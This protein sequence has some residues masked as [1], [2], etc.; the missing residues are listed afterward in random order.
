MPRK[1]AEQPRHGGRRP[2]S[3]APR[4]NLNAVKTGAQSAIIQ[5]GI[6]E[7]L[8]D[9]LTGHLFSALIMIVTNRHQQA[10]HHMLEAMLAAGHD[11]QHP[12]PGRR[13]ARA[14]V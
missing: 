2:G 4:G 1:A 13:T 5:Q 3:G 8:S 10:Q 11:Y 7:L 12:T 14:R 9:P 6:A